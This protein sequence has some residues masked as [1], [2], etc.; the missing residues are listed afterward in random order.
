[1]GFMLSWDQI[2]EGMATVV[3]MFC[4]WIPAL[5]PRSMQEHCSQHH[6]PAG[7]LS[8]SPTPQ[9][10]LHPTAVGQPREANWVTSAA[11]GSWPGP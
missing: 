1:M 3:A 2:R 5:P 10:T 9:P 8:G 11:S 4:S 7:L 6:L